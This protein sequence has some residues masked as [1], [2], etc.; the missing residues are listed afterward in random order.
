M[1]SGSG[2]LEVTGVRYDKT[3]A[4][5]DVVDGVETADAVVLTAGG[6]AFDHAPETSKS[7]PLSLLQEF[8][9]HLGHFPTTNGPH[10]TGDG[11]KVGVYRGRAIARLQP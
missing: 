10:A 3:P 8:A 9:P 6:Y 11:V 4:G 2:A 1:Q 7:R 5:G